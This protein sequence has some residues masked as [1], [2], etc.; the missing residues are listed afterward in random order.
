MSRSDIFLTMEIK[1][2]VG[3]SV[4]NICRHANRVGRI[5]ARESDEREEKKKSTTGIIMAR[6]MEMS[7]WYQHNYIQPYQHY[8]HQEQTRLD[9]YM[10]VK[11]NSSFEDSNG[12]QNSTVASIST[13]WCMHARMCL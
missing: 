10:R 6:W 13:P 8:Y 7:I 1:N 11:S 2:K 3:S 12:E 4:I 9:V 5:E